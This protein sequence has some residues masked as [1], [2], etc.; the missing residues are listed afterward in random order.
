VSDLFDM[1]E[2]T[3]PHFRTEL[4]VKNLGEPDENEALYR[5]RSPVTHVENLDA[6][7]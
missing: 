1:Y 5:E 4:M 3:M 6:P 7:S 2:N